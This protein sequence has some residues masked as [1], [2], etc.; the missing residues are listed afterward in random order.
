MEE[1]SDEIKG[2]NESVINEF[3]QKITEEYI[4]YFREKGNSWKEIEI[5]E[6]RM[7]LLKTCQRWEAMITR[8]PKLEVEELV[9][10]GLG[11]SLLWWRICNG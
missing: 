9:K 5:E 10:M 1:Q 11:A 4:R 6:L 3:A 7:T 2:L 8:Y